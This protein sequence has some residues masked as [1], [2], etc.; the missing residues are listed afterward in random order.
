MKAHSASLVFAVTFAACTQTTDAGE[1][2]GPTVDVTNT[3]FQPSEVTIKV[4][5]TV[6]W[7]W[8]SG[9]HNVASGTNCTDD[10]KFRS[11]DPVSG[12]TFDHKFDAPGT[13]EY[14]CE[15]HCAMGMTGKVIVQ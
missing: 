3:A 1:E 14:F 7:R 12:A 5:D 10:G 15:A 9:V 11:G 6:K 2:P 4:G 8:V 13:Y